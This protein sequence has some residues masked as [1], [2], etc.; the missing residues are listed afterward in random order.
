MS[1]RFLSRVAF[2]M[3]LVA[4]VTLGATGAIGAAAGAIG[5][6]NSAAAKTAAAFASSNIWYV[7]TSGHDTGNNCSVKTH[8]CATIQRALKEQASVAAGGTIDVAAGTY[9]GQYTLSSA[10]SDLD[11]KGVGKTTVLEPTSTPT[12]CATDPDTGA[13]VYAIICF[14]PGA[15]DV[16]VTSLS[17]NGLP[18]DVASLCGGSEYAGIYY[19]GATG[20]V[21]KVTVTGIDLPASCYSEGKPIGGTAIYVTSSNTPADSADVTISDSTITATLDESKTKTDLLAGSYTNGL[22]PVDSDKGFTRGSILVGGFLLSARKDNS[23]NL[24]ITGTAPEEIASGSTVNY[25]P[26]TG[27]YN[28]NGIACDDPDTTCRIAGNTITGEGETNQIAQNGILAWGT[29]AVT[30]SS[31]KVSGNTFTDGSVDGLGSNGSGIDLLNV[32]GG[33]VMSDTATSNDVDIYQGLVPLHSGSGFPADPSSFGS[34]TIAHNHTDDATADGESVEAEGFG[35]GIWLDGSDTTNSGGS[36]AGVTVQ[37]NV[38]T[39]NAA[40]GIFNTGSSGVEILGNTVTANEVGMTFGGPSQQCYDDAIENGQ[41]PG[42]SAYCN[43]GLPI[44]GGWGSDENTVASNIV[45]GT[46]A[47]AGNETGVVLDGYFATGKEEFDS[48]QAGAVGNI[49]DANT[50]DGNLL[51]DATDFAGTGQNTYGTGP[52]VNTCTPT[53]AGSASADRVLGPNATVSSVTVSTSTPDLTDN[54]GS[55]PTTSLNPAEPGNYVAAGGAVVD[56]T[57][58]GNIAAADIVTSVTGS[59]ADLDTAPSGNAA[60]D[61]ISFYNYLS[62]GGS[63]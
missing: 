2:R 10:N 28:K 8:P 31:N 44:S 4:G 63:L 60:A 58:P 50:W 21:S 17:I 25:S 22:L 33:T 48:D 57:T 45:G 18:G 47:G 16:K 38:A 51:A 62:C 24:Y 42:T 11:I 46:S 37:D 6:P 20:T 15:V 9:S 26:F 54:S 41:S 12:S 49:F 53:P 52:S 23:S 1:P 32:S 55:F 56:T 35:E 34:L 19:D 61:S 13:S 29:G 36:Q 30:I 5:G 43:P 27:G 59:T 14:A 7:A 40:A 3:S 39:G